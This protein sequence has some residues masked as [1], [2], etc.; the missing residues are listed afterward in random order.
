MTSDTIAISAAIGLVVLLVIIG[1]PTILYS[2]TANAISLIG[3]RFFANGTGIAYFDD[4]STQPFTHLITPDNGF[5][6]DNSTVFRAGDI[7]GLGSLNNTI[8]SAVRTTGL[9]PFPDAKT[10]NITI[11]YGTEL[12]PDDKTFQPNVVKV[13]VGDVIVWKNEDWQSHGIVS[14]PRINY[15]DTKVAEGLNLN[16]G[17]ILQGQQVA[18][19]LPAP[20]GYHYADLMNSNATGTIIVEER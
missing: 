9:S 14:P 18:I 19:F 15:T 20:G 10:V 3:E 4:G 7:P 2:T 13:R 8:S 12:L 1:V 16:T 6:Y 5:Y 11:P 17:L